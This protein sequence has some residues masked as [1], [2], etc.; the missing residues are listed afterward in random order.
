M[1]TVY[2]SIGNTDGKLS[3]TEWAEFWQLTNELLTTTV[4]TQIYGVWR[5]LPDSEYVNACWGVEV[6]LVHERALQDGL[7]E[8]AAK[9]RQDSIAYAAVPRTRFLMPVRALEE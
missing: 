3:Y 4:T 1:T 2:I 7:R 6:P 5:S 8:L 9:F